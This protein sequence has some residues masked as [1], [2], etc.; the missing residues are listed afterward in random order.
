[1]A[2]GSADL[3]LENCEIITCQPDLPAARALAIRNGRLLALG[4][5]AE[6]RQFAD[7]HTERLDCA[8]DTLAPGFVDAHCHLLALS[9]HLLSLDLSQARSIPEI[10]N[11]LDAR[12]KLSP[13]GRWVTA[14]GYNEFLLAERRAPDRWELDLHS[15]Q[16]PVLLIHRSLHACVLNSLALKAVGI[17]ET[18]EE[19]ADG[20]IER[21]LES[22]LP[23]G[24]LYEMLDWVKARMGQ[25]DSDV[26]A[27][28]IAAVDRH[29][30]SHGITSAVD[31]TVTNDLAR[32]QRFRTLKRD[33]KLHSRLGMFFGFAALPEMIES[34][35]R[36]G[37]GDRDLRL[38][39]FKIVLTEARGPLDPPQASLNQMAFE[40][41]RRSFPLAIHAVEA[42]TVA[43]ALAALEFVQARLPPSTR[44]WRIE[45]CSECPPGLTARLR[46]LKALVVSQP[47]FLYFSGDRYLATVSPEV[48]PW[49]YPF[50]SW[51]EAGLTVAAGSDAPVTPAAPLIGIYAAVTRHSESGRPI[52][53]EQAIS[54]AAALELH[55]L[56]AARAAGEEA[57][58]GSIAP[59]KLADLVQLSAN[60]LKVEPEALREIRVKRTLI[61]GKVVWENP[62]A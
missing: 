13:A 46:S 37:A 40:A 11:L 15:A 7:R 2:S 59:G 1:L 35:L 25:G 31:A 26:Q 50:K 27:E 17:D 52:H 43:A 28:G 54:P 20:V 14:G 12:I 5:D 49:L 45:H 23:N 21:D 51:F 53:P 41:A 38:A 55:T 60:P 56:G 9:Q 57:E 18:T 16:N 42:G 3:I 30:L 48:Q 8:G 47:A 19:P 61:G 29:L 10:L 62:S 34:G 33:G 39:G 44:L 4:T 58:R 32:W 24:I 22:G 6:V 36:P